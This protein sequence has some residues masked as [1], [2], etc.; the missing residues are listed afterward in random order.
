VAKAVWMPE[1]FLLRLS[2]LGEKTDE[3]ITKMLEAG[4]EVALEKVKDNLEAVIG[5]GTL[6]TSR[7]TGELVDALGISPV[8][9]SR[10]GT[11]NIKVGFSEPRRDGLSNAMLANIIEHGKHGQPAKPFLA[12]ARSASRKAVIKTMTEAFDLE[13][14]RL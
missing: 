12:P 14:E 9:L 4:G 5:R 2:R 13:V 1:E 10:D 7:S 6:R 3:I 11:L 8:K